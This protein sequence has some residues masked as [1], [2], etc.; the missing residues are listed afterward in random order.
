[1]SGEANDAVSAYTQVKVT[2]ASRLIKPPE[3]ECPT[4]GSVSLEAVVRNFGIISITQLSHK[5][6]LEKG[7]HWQDCCGTEDWTRS[8]CKKVGRKYPAGDL[9]LVTD[10][11]NSSY[12]C[13]SATKKAGRKPS[14]AN[15]R[16]TLK[17]KTD[18]EEPTPLIDQV[19][20]GCTQRESE[21]KDSMS[22]TKS[23]LFCYD[24]NY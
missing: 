4:L 5:A 7:F 2:D 10:K 19:F 8:C 21:T 6:A 22:K 1:M 23:D 15:M 13:T 9:S 20:S 14:F 12:E 16:L 18:L 3:R 17:K 24:H 11:L